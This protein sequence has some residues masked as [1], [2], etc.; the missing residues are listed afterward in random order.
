MSTVTNRI[1]LKKIS[2]NEILR[3]VTRHIN[4]GIGHS[5]MHQ[6]F[7]QFKWNNFSQTFLKMF[8]KTSAVVLLLALTS[9]CLEVESSEIQKVRNNKVCIIVHAKPLLKLCFLMYRNPNSFGAQEH[10]FHWIFQF[11]N[12]LGGQHRRHVAKKL[13]ASMPPQINAVT[14]ISA[15]R[16]PHSPVQWPQQTAMYNKELVLLLLE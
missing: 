6:R 7:S 14:T 16:I 15:A 2:R 5:I 9:F 3:Y 11:H 13:N 12:L 4:K 10:G 8:R 1:L